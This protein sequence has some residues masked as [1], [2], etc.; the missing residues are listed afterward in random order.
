MTKKFQN[1]QKKI[2]PNSKSGHSLKLG[3]FF[4]RENMLKE[5]AMKLIVQRPPRTPD[6]LVSSSTIFPTV[7]LS[8][9]PN[10]A[11]NLEQPPADDSL[12]ASG[13]DDSSRTPAIANTVSFSMLLRLCAVG[14]FMNIKPSEPYLTKYLRDYKHLSETELNEKVW[15]WNTYASFALLVPMAY[16]TE[17]FGYRTTILVGLLFRCVLHQLSRF[18][19]FNAY[20]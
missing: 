20:L 14:F 10:A 16:L 17:A 15:P 11:T 5:R 19:I 7:Q 1:A 18:D 8:L 13:N 3:T 2:P 4:A 6:V 9:S 12:A